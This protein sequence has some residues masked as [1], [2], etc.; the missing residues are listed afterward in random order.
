MFRGTELSD[1]LVRTRMVRQRNHT[2]DGSK[3][4]PVSFSRRRFLGLVC[5]SA[6]VGTGVLVYGTQVEADRLT[7]VRTDVPLPHWPAAANGLR[8]GQ[9]SDFHS[10]YPEAV[11]RTSR[12]VTML[13]AQKPDLVFVTGDYVT[14]DASLRFLRPTIEA[15]APLTQARLGAYAILGN[16]DWW[17]GI[18]RQVTHLL[19]ESGFKVLRNASA[20]FPG[21][22]GAYIVGLD[23]GWA[24]KMDVEKA[25]NGVPPGAPKLLALHEPDF[26]D[27]VGNSFDIQLSGH[28]H[29]GQV[30]V[31]GWGPIHC[32]EYGRRYPEGLQQA[33][34][35]LVYTTHG[36]GMIGPQIRV[37]CPPEVT[38]L[39][40]RTG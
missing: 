22:A 26:A 3:S 15:L 21:V 2:S 9:L 1:E 10:D 29:G 37:C 18:H 25:L 28:S 33:K 14:G 35:H 40:L 38:V 8:I 4:R 32:P 31:P 7:V 19:E 12:A 23:D 30:R 24:G 6:I 27:D 5:K 13:L 20:P 34:N 36:V 16:H 39:T 11:T 17:A